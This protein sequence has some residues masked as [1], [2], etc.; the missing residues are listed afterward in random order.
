MIFMLNDYCQ[1]SIGIIAFFLMNDD[2]LHKY[3][4]AIVIQYVCLCYFLISEL[5][6]HLSIRIA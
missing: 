2:L 1:M 6:A 4:L 3:I 5:I